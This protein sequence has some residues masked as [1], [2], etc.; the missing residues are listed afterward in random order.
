VEPSSRRTCRQAPRSQAKV[1]ALPPSAP[2]TVCRRIAATRKE[3][4]GL[5]QAPTG[6]TQ[7]WRFSYSA[8]A[9]WLTAGLT[10]LRPRDGINR[11]SAPADKANV[12]TSH[13]ACSNIS[14]GSLPPT[15]PHLASIL[16]LGVL[17]LFGH[18]AEIIWPCAE[19]ICPPIG[20]GAAHKDHQ[21]PNSSTAHDAGLAVTVSPASCQDRA[22]RG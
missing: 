4:P 22:A 8:D 12:M 14:P 5:C 19:I 11:P 3:S 9:I 15:S 21:Q 2:N 17:K 20:R 7:P 10:P 18:L 6:S 1:Q 13:A 16:S